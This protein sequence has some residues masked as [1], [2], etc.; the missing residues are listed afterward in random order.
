VI[1]VAYY[2]TMS[3]MPPGEVSRIEALLTQPPKATV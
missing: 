2:R 3:M 1:F